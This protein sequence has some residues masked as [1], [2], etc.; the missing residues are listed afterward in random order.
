MLGNRASSPTRW[1]Y[2]PKYNLC[3]LTAIFCEEKKA[4]AIKGSVYG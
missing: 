3:F 1:H 2:N 4:A